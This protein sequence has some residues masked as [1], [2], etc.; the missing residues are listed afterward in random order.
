MTYIVVFEVA[1]PTNVAKLKEA[2]KTYGSYCPVTEHS[3]AIISDKTPKDIVDHLALSIAPTD[4]IFVLR[5][6]TSAAWRNSFGE[7]NTNWLKEN[8]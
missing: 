5:S 3:W 2:L 8:L 7:L 1:S 6:G 4:R